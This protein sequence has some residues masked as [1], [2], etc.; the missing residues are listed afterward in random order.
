MD[1]DKRLVIRLPLES[2]WNGDGPL[3][4]SRR[5]D[6]TAEDIKALLRLG[7]VSFVVADCGLPLVWTAPAEGYDFWKGEI[8]PHLYDEAKPHLDDYPG[9]YF[10]SAS[11][12]QV[13]ASQSVVVLEEHH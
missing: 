7:A 4:A 3:D 12:W 11:E 2:L 9:G 8:Q 1:T 6:L 13:G 5:R 10:Y